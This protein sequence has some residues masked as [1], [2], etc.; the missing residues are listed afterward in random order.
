M[1]CS[2]LALFVLGPEIVVL[3]KRCVAGPRCVLG[4]PE[5]G[6][7]VGLELAVRLL[8][9]LGLDRVR[10]RLGRRR[11]RLAVKVPAVRIGLS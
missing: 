2:A 9:A 7:E 11:E 1:S 10:S 4:D 5:L 6:L 8:G 3:L